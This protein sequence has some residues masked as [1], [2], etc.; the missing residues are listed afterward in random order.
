MRP[1]AMKSLLEVL[2]G[3]RSALSPRQPKA[4]P[5][6]T[7]IRPYS[8][9][10]KEACLD[11]YNEAEPGRFPAGARGEFERFL[12]AP[13]Y[14]KLICSIDENPV[15]VGGIGLIPGLF[16]TQVW[17]VFGM[18]RP[19]LHGRGIGTAMLLARLGALHCPEKPVRVLLS[20]V[21]ASEGFYASLGFVHQGQMPVPQ[22][23]HCW[24]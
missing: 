9:S 7:R 22:A 10:D 20:S 5:L 12:E 24:M 16:S 8:P 18:V 13:G 15:A 19:A 17:L 14:L 1:G 23:G 2:T 3:P 4:L 21:M 6:G 11:I